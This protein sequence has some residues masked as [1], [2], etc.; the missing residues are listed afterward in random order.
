MGEGHILA[1]NGTGES[2]SSSPYM[3]RSVPQTLYLCLRLHFEKDNKNISLR[4][5]FS[6]LVTMPTT[7]KAETLYSFF[8]F[9]SEYA[10]AAY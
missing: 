3:V 2:R 6:V 8:I 4:I 5:A 10:G 1:K 7:G 9:G